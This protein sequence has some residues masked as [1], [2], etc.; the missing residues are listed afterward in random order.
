MAGLACGV[1]ALALAVFGEAWRGAL[2]D[3]VRQAYYAAPDSSLGRAFAWLASSRTVLPEDFYL[4]RV[5][6]AY[7]WA[8]T[9]VGLGALPRRDFWRC[10]SAQAR[11]RRWPRISWRSLSLPGSLPVAPVTKA[12]RRPPPGILW[13]C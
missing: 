7:R 9:L 4:A 11:G 8:N 10:V 5:Y 2:G 13:V 3:V 1:I 6:L 12:I